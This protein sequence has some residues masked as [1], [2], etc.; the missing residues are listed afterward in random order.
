MIKRFLISSAI[1]ILTSFGTTTAL[2]AKAEQKIITSSLANH[3][4]TFDGSTRT[5]FDYKGISD[6]KIDLHNKGT[7][8]FRFTIKSPEDTVIGSGRLEP[9][10]SMTNLFSFSYADWLPEGEY[11]ISVQNNDGSQGSLHMV[12]TLL[13]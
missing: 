11:S 8:T 7:T 9:G 13:E 3:E 12:A 10:Q 5:G 1:F 2:H 4:I 6:L